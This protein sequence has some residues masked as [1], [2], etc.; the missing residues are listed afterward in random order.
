MLGVLIEVLEEVQERFEGV[1]EG[2]FAQS[3]LVVLLKELAIFPEKLQFHPAYAKSLDGK[4]TRM[5]PQ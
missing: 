4:I 1:S 3:N 5:L 2:I